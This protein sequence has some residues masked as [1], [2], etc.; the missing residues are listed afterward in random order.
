MTLQD[1]TPL[2]QPRG[3]AALPPSEFARLRS[4]AARRHHASEAVDGDRTYE[5]EP[6]L[7]KKVAGI[8]FDTQSGLSKNV[9][10]E[11]TFSNRRLPS[12]VCG[13]GGTVDKGNEPMPSSWTQLWAGA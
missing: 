13:V 5:P 3:A 1:T 8:W 12:F 9:Q 2:A 6:W 7:S 10:L 4:H 11:Y